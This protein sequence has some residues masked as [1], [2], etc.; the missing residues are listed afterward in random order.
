MINEANINPPIRTHAGLLI[1]EW[2]NANGSSF[3]PE[4]ICVMFCQK[5]EKI[6]SDELIIVESIFCRMGITKNFNILKFVGEYY[7]I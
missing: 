7:E 2:R 6:S 1:I 5:S 4:N 3:I